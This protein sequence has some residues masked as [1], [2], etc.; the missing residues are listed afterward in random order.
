[1]P[2]AANSK[3][4]CGGPNGLSLYQTKASPSSS[5]SGTAS[6]SA[7][8]ST[9]SK[10]PTGPTVVP[11]ASGYT[12]LGCHSEVP[13]GRAL[14]NLYANSSMT[15]EMCAAQAVRGTYRFFGVEYGSECWYGNVLA[16][17]AQPIDQSR[18]GFPCPG[19]AGEYCGAGNSLQLYRLA[20]DASASASVSSNSGQVSTVASS[21][22]TATTASSPT[23]QS[24]ERTIETST[25]TSMASSGTSSATTRTSSTTSASASAS[26]TPL[27]CPKSNGTVYQ[28]NNATKT[29]NFIIEC[30][31]D[32]AG[33]DMR[34]AGQYIG[35]LEDCVGK[36]SNHLS[37]CR[38]RG[39][40]SPC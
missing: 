35:S 20:G 16:P 8:P 26:T 24:D 33:G 32:H 15:I 40:G 36:V 34:G 30:G 11:R 6:R 10:T 2:C 4:I 23:A 31:L 25:R 9:T 13:N 12:S 7:G 22:P 39:V 37:S 3:Q 21:G 38:F 27:A 28:A 19:D 5:S 17:E 29:F 1:M 18:C 14:P